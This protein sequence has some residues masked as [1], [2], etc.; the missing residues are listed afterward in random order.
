MDIKIK[1]SG[2]WTSNKKSS[3]AV[4]KLLAVAENEPEFSSTGQTFRQLEQVVQYT[5]RQKAKSGHCFETI[6][7]FNV[8]SVF[9]K[10]E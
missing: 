8:K 4:V 5:Y 3:H 9:Q 7:G 6:R 1:Q 10:C 2:L